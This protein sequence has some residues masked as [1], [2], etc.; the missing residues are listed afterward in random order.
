MAGALL[1]ASLWQWPAQAQTGGCRQALVLGLDVSGSVDASE[2]AI[3]RRG[4]AN[5][6]RHREVRA[7]L[8][9]LPDLP[10]ALMV[11][12]WSGAGQHA[13]ITGWHLMKSDA[14]IDSVAAMLED[15][16]T[17]PTPAPTAIGSAILY[18][19]DA[20]SEVSA[21]LHRTLDLSGDGK[22]NDGPLITD[23]H[24]AAERAG[25]TINGLVIGGD[26]ATARDDR[27]AQIGELVAYYQHSVILGPGAFVEAALGF[28]DFERAMKRK[29]LRELDGFV[30]GAAPQPKER[31]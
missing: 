27:A 29:L 16:D 4:L 28:E 1:L 23:A 3:Q 25:V 5:A 9:Q 24:A 30:F 31:P 17:R 18:A 10:V 20:F 19:V 12:E 13:D 14:A 26:T 2:Y 8:L 6:L 7:A 21:C 11:F 22:S 15:I